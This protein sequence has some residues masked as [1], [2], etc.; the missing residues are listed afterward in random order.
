[1]LHERVAEAFHDI[2]AEFLQFR[3]RKVQR[4]K[5]FVEHHLLDEGAHD[6]VLTAFLYRIQAAQVANRRQHGVR[7][8]QQ[9]HLA[10]MVRGL[11]RD[12]EHVQAGFVG[13]E[14]GGDFLRS[15]NHPQVEDF[16]LVQQVVLVTHALAQLGGIVA[17]ITRD[18]AVHQR[19]IYA[20]G[21]LEPFR[22]TFSQ[23][24]QVDVLADAFLQVLAV[25]ENQLAREEDHALGR[26]A[27]EELVP[28]VQELGQFAGIGGRGGILELA[29]RIEGDTRLGGVGDDETHLRLFGQFHIS[30][31]I[32]I[33]IDTPAD[34]INQVHAVHRLSVQE[35]LKVQVIQAVLLVQHVDHTTV[36]GLDHDDGG[37]EVRL[38]VGFPDDPL[39]ESPQEVAFAELDDLLGIMFR[40]R[41]S[42]TIQSFH[43]GCKYTLKFVIKL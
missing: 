16:S 33:G 38:L 23:F 4:R 26:I 17:R 5:Q 6:S 39:D 37:I 10:L 24:P 30:L 36:D 19:A 34:D 27:L 28:M 42:R 14:L 9:G 1:M 43:I 32:S 25:F 40:L 18:D 12:E 35:T 7:A 31:E 2:V 22:E 3:F 11:R 8:V 15:L 21:G 29:G 20:A 41:C 13:R